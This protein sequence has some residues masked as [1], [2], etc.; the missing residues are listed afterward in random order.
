[1]ESK[2]K[3][4]R[5]KSIVY[6]YASCIWLFVSLIII[7]ST[8]SPLKNAK[9]TVLNYKSDIVQ[10]NKVFNEDNLFYKPEYLEN[11]EV[12]VSDIANMIDFDIIYSLSLSKAYS[13]NYTIALDSKLIAEDTSNNNSV[14]W[15]R[16][17]DLGTPISETKSKN[18]D[19]T[20]K[21][22]F[23][24]DYATS[25]DTLLKYQRTY[26]IRVN[27]YAQI[28]VK[29]SINNM[30]DDEGNDI[31]IDTDLQNYKVMRII[32]PLMDKT[33]SITTEKDPSTQKSINIINNN[34]LVINKSM[35]RLGYVL[36]IIGIGLL[37]VSLVIKKKRTTSKDLYNKRLK[38]IF[39]KYEEIIV[40]IEKLPV[41]SKLKKM[42]VLEF[43]DLV[44][45]E[46]EINSPILL[47]SYK[48]KTLFTIIKANYL[49]YYEIKEDDFE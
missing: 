7:I 8:F 37:I 15:E 14:I 32:I 40:R 49:Y 30:Y 22:S 2:I 48:H 9:T 12:Y 20:I 45:I 43:N 44:D 11:K 19:F 3:K 21:D 23:D 17:V 24:F 33:F 18:T 36:F 10:S 41:D 46:Q 35:H 38:E 47:T 5:I 1:M 6:I 31:T 4:R 29:I 25:R 34:I 42:K 26:G 27:G 39:S 28:D 16:A 13:V